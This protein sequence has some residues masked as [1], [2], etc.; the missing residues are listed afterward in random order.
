LDGVL[1]QL[2]DAVGYQAEQ[3]GLELLI[4]YDPAIPPRL[5]G[6][7]LRLGQILL[8]LCGNAIK[9]TKQGEIELALRCLHL[10]PTEVTVQVSVR[11]TGIGM[12]PEA[13][14]RL[15]EKFSQ[16]DQTTTRRYGGTGLGLASCKNLV[17]MMGG[18][19]WVEDSQPG[20]GSTL[21]FTVRLGIA[22]QAQA[23]QRELVEQAGPL[24]QGLRVLVVD[25][26]QVS[27]E[28]LTG[29]LRFFRLDV[30][31][32]PN[33][34][35]ALAAL[36]AAAA[37]PYDL[38]LMDWRMPGM[39]GD[40][41]A[42]HMHRDAAIVRQPKVVMITA[43]G[44]EDV[45]RLAEQAGVDGF[46]IKPVSPSSLLDTMLSVL[47]R[48]R[49][50]RGDGERADGRALLARS[51][52]IAGA[53]LLLVEDNDINREFAVELLRS[54]GV[55][56][57]EAV[58]GEQAVRQ[59]QLRDYDGVLMD[60]QMPV[61]DGL[62]AA[63]RIRALATAPGGERFAHLPIIAMTALAMAR[64]TQ[65]SREAG[66][67]DHVT[68]PI[69]PERLMAVLTRWVK[70]SEPRGSRPAGLAVASTTATLRGGELPADLAA[71]TCIDAVEG[72]RRIGGKSEAFRKQL[73][74][75][76]ERYPDAIAELRRLTATQGVRQA[77][78]RCH[79]LK[80]VAG[81]LGAHALYQKVTEIDAQLKKGR[82]ADAEALDEAQVLLQQL[83]QEIDGLAS[84]AAPAPPPPAAPLSPDAVQDLLA[85]L[86]QALD[87]DIGAAEPLLLALRSGV[88]G[89]PLA[90][91]IDEIAEQVDGFEMDAA[92]AAIRRLQHP[93]R[94]ESP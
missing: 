57:D 43:Y 18:R 88:A 15:F 79:A 66:M 35:A 21:C 67:N 14:Q 77:E 73:L 9:F 42:Q 13:Q 49:I 24:L 68:K 45:M 10:D 90:A 53:R 37:E 30:G 55:E 25:D 34:A 48:G 62:E 86:A 65:K 41:V 94:E 64:D 12:S 1:E 8:N 52:Q 75:F 50:F 29:M 89:T 28:I 91:S 78:E 74:R 71:M 51:G 11:D 31:T 93:S 26:N 58:D 47:G 20:H 6:D 70:L 92:M 84:V 83:M 39:N 16:A 33:G 61:M 59:V 76:R 38:V 60:V 32:A 17:T 80:G 27:R 54:E 7:P 19:I 87:Y 40:E 82:P 22:A 72:V 56:V 23:R 46:L 44:R 36:R 81:N 5:M 4:R 2:S 63:R 69:A 85:R 3:K